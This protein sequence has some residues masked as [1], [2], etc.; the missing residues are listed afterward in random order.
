MLGAGQSWTAWCSVFIL[1]R[2]LF[3]A[4]K[5]KAEL[6]GPLF[7]YLFFCVKSPKFFNF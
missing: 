3:L 6:A 1:E 7:G 4:N 5:E 2:L